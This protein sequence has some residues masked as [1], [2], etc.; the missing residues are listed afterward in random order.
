MEL[1]ASSSY[2]KE[3]FTDVTLEQVSLSRSSF[4]DCTIVKCRLSGVDLTAADFA[5]CVFEHC[6][7][8]LPKLINTGLHGVKFVDCKL[9]G[10]DFTKI[11]QQFF[12]VSFSN[13]LVEMCNFSAL[14]MKKMSFVRCVLRET[15]FVESQ[16]SEANFEGSDLDGAVFHGCHLEKANFYQAKN[17]SIDPRTNNIQGA[18]FSLPEAISLIEG[19]G[20]KLK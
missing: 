5:D 19:L 11:S 1:A 20:V 18:I 2:T 6:E 9:V 7:M 10:A 4:T 17:Y 8:S 16:L 3:T 12:D 15:R 13:C 14:K